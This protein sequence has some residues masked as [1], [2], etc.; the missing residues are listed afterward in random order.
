[1][2]YGK[3]FEKYATKH[4]G[5]NSN[6]YQKIV[7][8]VTPTGMT[9]N[10]IEERQ[11]NA[12]AMD[13]FSRLMMDRIIFMGTAINDQV[14]NIIQAQMLFLESTDA[15][16][17][18]QIYINSPGGSVYAGLGIYDTM[19]FIKP[20]VATICTGMAAS[21][22]AVLLCAGEK[23]KRSGLPH[24]RVM[25]HQPLGGAQGQASD[26]EITAREILTLKKELYDIIAKHSG[27]SYEKIEEDSDRD[28]WMKAEKAKEYGMIDEI[29]TREG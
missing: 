21:M 15:S 26:I 12:V 17:D 8:S 19:Q 14:A 20:D 23:G 11:M 13:V 28:Y 27:Q 10:I 5:I 18:I 7:S 22:G 6:Y 3:E 29:L 25:I 4:H 16:K 2:D 9:P 24:S 1:M